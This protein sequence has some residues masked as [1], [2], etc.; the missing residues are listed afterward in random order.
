MP[1][2]TFLPNLGMGGSPV[3]EAPFEGGSLGQSQVSSISFYVR[4]LFPYTFPIDFSVIEAVQVLGMD[5][6]PA[7]WKANRIFT[8]TTPYWAFQISTDVFPP[9]ATPPTTTT[10]VTRIRS[11]THSTLRVVGASANRISLLSSSKNVVRIL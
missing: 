2:L 6:D 3:A 4:N 5:A 7:Q 8:S 10:T 11:S 9:N 1:L